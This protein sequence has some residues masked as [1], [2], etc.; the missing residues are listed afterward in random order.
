M[1]LELH[2]LQNFAPSCLNRD[3]TN[4]PK[5]CV[6]GGFRRARISSQCIKR[7]IRKY[8]LEHAPDMGLKEHV[9]Q[10]TKMLHKILV[11][12]IE[13]SGKK[14]DEADSLVRFALEGGG[15]KMD[16]DK[17][18]V[19]LYLDQQ[20]IERLKDAL[21]SC[22]KDL[23]Q[24]RAAAEKAPPAPSDAKAKKSAKEEKKEKQA[25]MPESVLKAFDA[26][27]KSVTG[28][29]DIALFGRMV[30]ELDNMNVDAACQVA[31][32]FSTHE[33]DMEMDFYTAVDDLQ[34]KEETGAGMMGIV[35]FNSSCFYRYGLLDLNQ[36]AKNLDD[37]KLAALA[38]AA[39]VKASIHAI[40]TG[41]Q[42]SMAA[43]NP[44]LY[45]RLVLRN[46]GAPRSLANAFLQPARPDRKGEKD[47]GLISVEKAEKHE[48]DLRQMYGNAGV[49]LDFRCSI[50]EG[51]RE[52]S[53]EDL[54]RKL[55]EKLQ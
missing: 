28:A 8:F 25:Q 42:N 7:S 14:R 39:F 53:V 40:P 4:A 41:K 51:H 48:A 29:A 16:G 5:D 6:F 35:E 49:V 19:L 38:A 55:K 46:E 22:W 18:S 31:H 37:G 54:L 10:R 30:A 9:G 43:Q 2:I 52:G 44:P 47:L 24:A 21:L 32:A 26:I 36:L 13:K 17:T 11:D 20:A 45:V 1:Q 12:M 50:Y 23:V 34:P 15:L 33:V 27:K 3:D